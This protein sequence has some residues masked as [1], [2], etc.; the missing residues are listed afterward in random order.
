MQNPGGYLVCVQSRDEGE[1]AQLKGQDTYFFLNA[2][3]IESARREAG[4]QWEKIRGGN[5]GKLFWQP[6]FVWVESL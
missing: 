5:G 1:V 2:Q 6:Q 4:Q 3:D